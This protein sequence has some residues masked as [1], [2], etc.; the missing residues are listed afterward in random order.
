MVEEFT[1]N[2]KREGDIL[3]YILTKEFFS[4]WIW[5]S[6]GIG[7]NLNCFTHNEFRN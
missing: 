2:E 6:H 7:Q 1:I 3:H 4:A 5:V